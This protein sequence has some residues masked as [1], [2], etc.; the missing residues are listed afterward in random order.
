VNPAR[1]R[2]P[3]RSITDRAFDQLIPSELRHLSARHWTPVDVAIRA[4]SL[5][6]P[7]QGA[8]ILDVG[9]GAGKLC[10]VGALSSS[11]TWCGIEQHESL[12][13]TARRLAR[14]LGVGQRT[15]FVQ[16]DVFSIDWRDFDALYL[17]N[18]FEL[19]VFQS[20]PAQHEL[21]YSVQIARVQDRLA[22]LPAGVRVVTYH[23]FGGVIPSSFELVYQE[24]VPSVGLDLVLWM[25]GAR[26]RREPGWS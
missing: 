19:P 17:Y 21:Q 8:R 14:A 25:Q 6:C 7:T 23:G 4:T 22:S 16:G 15:M 20:D 5:L 11:A 9:S 10:A 26:P 13:D 12:V 18:P 2:R 1:K 24:R 3:G